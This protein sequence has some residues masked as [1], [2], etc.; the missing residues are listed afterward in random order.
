MDVSFDQTVGTVKEYTGS[1]ASL[2]TAS[3]ETKEKNYLIF[4][5]PF[6]GISGDLMPACWKGGFGGDLP[7]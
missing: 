6:V 4:C 2:P 7:I 3:V 1:S 5:V